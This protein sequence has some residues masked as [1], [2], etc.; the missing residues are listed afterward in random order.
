MDKSHLGKYKEAPVPLWPP[1]Q[2][3][4]RNSFCL[5]STLNPPGAE[6][7]AGRGASFQ[8][9]SPAPVL[10]TASLAVPLPVGDRV[11]RVG[12]Q[13]REEGLDTIESAARDSVREKAGFLG[14]PPS[15]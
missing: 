3:V 8:T 6:G 12:V 2:T 7:K 5:L 11:Y 13:M 1:V 9:S 4:A 15:V 10:L 14:D